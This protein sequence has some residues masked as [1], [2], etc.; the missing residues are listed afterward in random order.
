MKTDLKFKERRNY[1]HSTDFFMWLSNDVCTKE[2]IVSKL[3]FKSLIQYQCELLWEKSSDFAVGH[4][5]LKNTITSEVIKASIVETNERIEQRYSFN[6]DA[7]VSDAVIDNA[8]K[9]ITTFNPHGC[10]TI[11]MVVALTKKLHNTL[12]PVSSK[13][14]LVGQMMFTTKL[15][16]SYKDISVNILRIMKNRFSVSDI[17]IDGSCIGAV[18]FIVGD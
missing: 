17:Y 9:K 6:E 7:L 16:S 5:E 1:L 13:K 11:E 2:Q 10:S 12:Y 8:A 4:V 3:T 15:P 18:Q 14:W